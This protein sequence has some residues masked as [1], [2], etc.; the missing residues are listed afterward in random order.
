METKENKGAKPMLKKRV[1]DAQPL[2]QLTP[3]PKN[4][5]TQ[6]ARTEHWIHPEIY[7]L[8][9]VETA[10]RLIDP[11]DFEVA[12]ESEQSAG[13]I[14][15]RVSAKS[16]EHDVEELEYYFY[17]KLILA[18]TTHHSQ[19]THSEIRTLFMQ[20]AHNVTRQTWQALGWNDA[21]T[22]SATEAKEAETPPEVPQ[23]HEYKD[24]SYVVDETNEKLLITVETTAY[25]LPDVLS[26]AS[27]IRR[28]GW[29]VEVDARGIPI[30]VV[31]K[32]KNNDIMA[33]VMQF[34]DGLNTAEA[35]VPCP[36]ATECEV[37]DS[38]THGKIEGCTSQK[39]DIDV[40]P[41]IF[42][43][44]TIQLAALLVSDRFHIKIDG[45]P[46]QQI[47][48]NLKPK[49]PAGL[50]NVEDVFYEALIQ[51][52]LDEYKLASYEP[53][54]AYFLKL[55]LSFGP[56]LENV[57]LSSFFRKQ[58]PKNQNLD[59][60]IAVNGSEICLSVLGR[61]SAR[62]PLFDVAWRLR[63]KGTFAFHPEGINGIRVK[64]QP[65]ANTQVEELTN[66][67][68]CELQ[69]CLAF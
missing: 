3:L 36:T 30:R 29:E 51:A 13:H 64:V 28:T 69:R 46:A 11:R 43:L 7:P 65:K 53:I 27:E 35:S 49:S 60:R 14:I 32:L 45:D 47:R 31:V 9:V 2:L 39:T 23:T 67:L 24:I 48:V 63:S 42:P 59:Y 50:G 62:I 44:P 22:T 20:T 40:Y 54:R 57:S 16:Y 15:V 8:P 61:E 17:R 38:P 5:R 56:V 66:T 25:G 6:K 33:V 1:S 12:W 55:A 34:H 52:S 4:R 41:Q 37:E 10:V 58:K 26:S 68:N 18:S 21:F 19:Q